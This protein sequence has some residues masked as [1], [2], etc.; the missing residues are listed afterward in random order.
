MPG[1]TGGVCGL[2]W[3]EVEQAETLAFA[4]PLHAA[5]PPSTSLPLLQLPVALASAWILSAAA[6]AAVHFER[7][8]PVSTYWPLQKSCPE[9]S[10][11]CAVQPPLSMAWQ[12]GASYVARQLPWHVTSTLASQVP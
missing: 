10:V 9:G 4:S 11:Q 3:G 1:A 12:D 2:S 8:S 7:W 5:P 6:S